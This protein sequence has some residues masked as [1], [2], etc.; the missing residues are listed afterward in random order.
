M[1][2]VPYPQE[3]TMW[4]GCCRLK[5]YVADVGDELAVLRKEIGSKGDVRVRFLAVS[6]YPEE[7]RRERLND[8]Q[9]YI[10]TIQENSLEIYAN[11]PGGHFSGAMTLL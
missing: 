9:A 6:E 3:V 7:L 5:P 11:S 4:E 1:K 10:L 2:L 8:P